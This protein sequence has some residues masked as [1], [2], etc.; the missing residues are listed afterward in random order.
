MN[1]AVFHDLPSGG[2]KRTLFE[3]V[4]RLSASHALNEYTLSTADQRYCDLR[5]WVRSQLI[6]PFKPRHLFSSPFGR[7]N[8]LQRWRDLQQLDRLAQEIAG[9]IDGEGHD[10][11]FAHPCIWTQAPLLLRHLRTPSVYYLHEPP[12]ALYEEMP[13]RDGTTAAWR[14]VLDRC[15]PLISL[16]R[17]TARRLDWQATRAAGKVLVNSQFM[18][19]TV[20]RIYGI[21]ACLCYHGIDTQM[22]RPFPSAD[23]HDYVLSVGA[24]QP[25]KGFAFLIESLACLPENRRP[26]LRLVGNAEVGTETQYLQHLAAKCGVE[27]SVEVRLDDQTLVR[28]YNEAALFAYAPYNEP[29]G[30]AP[31]EAMACGTPVVGVAEGG[32]CETVLDGVTGYLVPR[33]QRAFGEAV[34][35]MLADPV[36]RKRLGEQGL[37]HVRENW[38]WE[39]ALKRIEEHL[40][41]VAGHNRC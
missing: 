9:Q 16:Y 14:R 22:F 36:K 18:G 33:D 6:F 12:R 15:D 23:K 29:F 37:N 8:Q 35:A 5:P 10:V 21:T 25:K 41:T 38:T 1:L 26:P 20:S 40:S 4:K 24:I 11:V 39:A 17:T 27:L 32:V 7:L 28:R 2:A 31:L 3:M 19:R 30:L 13:R 34:L